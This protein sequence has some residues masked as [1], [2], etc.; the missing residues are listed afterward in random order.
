MSGWRSVSLVC[1]AVVAASVLWVT[2]DVAH[3]SARP[4]ATGTDPTETWPMFGHDGL[5][6]AAATDSDVTSLTAPRLH[7]LWS[8]L[9]GTTAEPAAA[10]PV[11]AFNATL[12]EMLVYDINAVGGVGAFDADTGK[13]IWQTTLPYG[14]VG[15]DQAQDDVSTP[16]IDGNTLYVGTTGALVAMDAT[17]GAID[18]SFPTPVEPPATQPGIIDSSPVV[19]DFDPS[20]PI[21]FFGDKGQ[22]EAFNGGHEWA[23]TGV[24][25]TAGACQ[26]AWVFDGWQDQAHPNKLVGS[27]SSPALVQD[28]TGTWLL[29]FGSS[30]PDD[31]VYALDASTGALVWRFQ[32]PPSGPDQDVGAGPTISPPGANGFPDGVVYVE[33]KDTVEFAIDLSTGAQLWSFD[34]GADTGVSVDAVSSGALDGNVLYVPYSEWVYAF[35]ATTGAVLWRTDVGGGIFYSSSS[36][37]IP[38][39]GDPG[40]PVLFLGNTSG[41][42][43]AIDA[44]SGSV[45]ATVSLG[46]AI[47]SSASISGTEVFE[48]DAIGKIVALTVDPVIPKVALSG[49]PVAGDNTYGVTVTVP[50]GDPA[51]TG[52]VTVSDSGGNSCAVSLTGSGTTY[53]GSCTI[54]AET[55]GTKVTASIGSDAEYSAANSSQTLTVRAPVPAVSDVSPDA[56][57]L[58]G[59]TPVTITGSGF[60]NGAKV[61]VGGTRAVNVHFVSADELT[62]TTPSGTAGTATVLVT[63]VGGTSPAGATGD[64]FT[65][66]PVPV[67]TGLSSSTA[68]GTAGGSTIDVYGSGFTSDATVTY[69]QGQGPL[70]NAVQWA[71]TAVTA[72]DITATV[73]PS[74]AGTF[75]VFV[76]TPG[77]T[78]K[79]DSSTSFTVTA[80]GPPK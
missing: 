33:G 58:K 51:P 15:P 31:A 27:W 40:D 14:I 46:S 70:L 50:A 24:G 41:D 74:K 18:C 73:G 54:V 6:S 56:G 11:I 75:N 17:T 80:G 2:A 69:S 5:H 52:S 36:I 39:T 34:M 20:G 19:G 79:S 61:T 21:V 7:V 77:G 48:A 67:V 55:V 37:S 60:A 43:F 4:A 57:P 38:A 68:V 23:V 30:D 22:S 49:S 53:T 65:Y 63:T 16:A 9:A 8:H 45:L 76:T 44:T 62:A 1:A 26:Q 13:M 3:A 59:G 12:G 78:S 25:N 72:T 71:V 32:T 66:D 29:V 64:S 35:D 42:V 10:S 28:A 47:F